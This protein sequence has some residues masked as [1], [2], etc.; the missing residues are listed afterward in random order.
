MDGN[1]FYWNDMVSS[2][3]GY[4]RGW[5]STVPGLTLLVPEIAFFQAVKDAKDIS[6]TATVN[7][8]RG[9]ETFTIDDEDNCSNFK[10]FCREVCSN[11]FHNYCNLSAMNAIAQ[12][13]PMRTNM[14][15]ARYSY[16]QKLQ[17][18]NCNSSIS[19]RTNPDPDARRYCMI[20]KGEIVTFLED[21]GNGF[22]KIEYDGW[23]GYASSLYLG[24]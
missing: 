3:P 15:P 5:R 8:R 22:F 17:V 12:L 16:G 10:V 4:N 19:L 9:Y 13:F 1:E 6:I 24:W 18:I 2:N 23:T 21:A 20:P 7:G 14:S 11:N